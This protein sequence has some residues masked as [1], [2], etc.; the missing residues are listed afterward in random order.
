MKTPF[1]KRRGNVRYDVYKWYTAYETSNV[2]RVFIRYD[3]PCSLGSNC[4]AGTIIGCDP[5][6]NNCM[7]IVENGEETGNLPDD[8]SPTVKNSVTGLIGSYDVYIKTK[9]R[10]MATAIPSI[11]RWSISTM[12]RG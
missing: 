7:T 4:F 11:H 2:E 12:E 10:K 3:A 1:H 5:T 6:G 8:N 9:P